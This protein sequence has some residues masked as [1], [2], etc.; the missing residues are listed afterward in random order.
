MEQFETI[1][2][3]WWLFNDGK[4]VRPLTDNEAAQ[5]IWGLGKG[6]GDGY[7]L[8]CGL[9]K[10]DDERVQNGMKCEQCAY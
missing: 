9:Y 8:E 6:I 7:C 10:P 1:D 3:K 5:V 2:G 4:K